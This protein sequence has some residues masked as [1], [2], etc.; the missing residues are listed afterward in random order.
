MKLVNM[1]F[2]SFA[3]CFVLNSI[4]AFPID[5]G[6]PV[7]TPFGESLPASLAVDLDNDGDLEIVLGAVYEGMS[8]VA[9]HHDGS[10]YLPFEINHTGSP[11]SPA[12]GDLNQ[13]GTLEVVTALSHESNSKVLVQDKDGNMLPGWPQTVEHDMEYGSLA[14]GDLTG[15]GNLEIVVT[16]RYAVYLFNLHGELLPHWPYPMNLL[17]NC[18]AV[19]DLNKDGKQEIIIASSSEFDTGRWNIL[20]VVDANAISQPGW[21]VKYSQGNPVQTSPVVGDID[22]DHDLEVFASSRHNDMSSYSDIIAYHHDGTEV[23]NW[24][25]TFISGAIEG[26]MAS[27]ALADITGDGIAEL[28]INDPRADMWI[29]SGDAEIVEGW[30]QGYAQGGR[31][32]A[33]PVVCDITGDGGLEI[34]SVNNR[35][36]LFNTMIWDRFGVPLDGFPFLSIASNWESRICDDLDGDG[37][38]EI[39]LSGRAGSTV[40][41]LVAYDLGPGTW[42]Q[43]RR[44][45]TT[46]QAD[47]WRTGFYPGS[48]CPLHVSITANKTVYEGGDDFIITTAVRNAGRTIDGTLYIALQDELDNFYWYPSFTSDV[49]GVPITYTHLKNKSEILF[50][51]TLVEPL[52]SGVLTLWMAVVDADGELV[53]NVSNDY[54]E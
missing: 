51:G 7:K 13:D 31:T 10:Q 50:E 54:F 47:P 18:T 48:H 25:K 5:P 42:H 30:P 26:L 9:L 38:T 11:V 32:R 28:L 37:S 43:H 17:M 12:V 46:E 53:S 22:G 19:G 23:E 21:P 8:F 14:L 6:W 40:P 27:P 33:A 20:Y 52:N 24:P 2:A 1:C 4:A 36:T 29:F 45:W 49:A 35:T 41:R 34:I 15:D 3:F 39:V 16:D 44:P